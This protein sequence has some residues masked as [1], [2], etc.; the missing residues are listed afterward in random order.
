MGGEEP[1]GRLS[2]RRDGQ[3]IGTCNGVCRRGD[4]SS[5]PGPGTPV[6][7]HDG[8]VVAAISLGGPGTRLTEARIP[9]LIKSVRDSA[10]RISQRLGWTPM[11]IPPKRVPAPPVGRSRQ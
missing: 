6:R 11:E 10:A 5:A 4:S 7:R 9:G 2:V 1:P 8:Q 3:S